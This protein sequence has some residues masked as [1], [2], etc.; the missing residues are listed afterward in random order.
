MPS[1]FRLVMY[2]I[3]AVQMDSQVFVLLHVAGYSSLLFPIHCLSLSPLFP[4][5]TIADSPPSQTTRNA[6]CFNFFYS[7]LWTVMKEQTKKWGKLF[8]RIACTQ[9]QFGPFCLKKRTSPNIALCLLQRPP[10]NRKSEAGSLI[11]CWPRAVKAGSAKRI[12]NGS[13][14][15]PRSRYA[16]GRDNRH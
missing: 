6:F 2:A 3:F 16:G 9:L 10:S 5:N 11:A 15:I 4:P 12:G 7:A 8:N 1:T 14:V 13:G